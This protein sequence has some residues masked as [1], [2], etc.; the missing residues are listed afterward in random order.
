VGGSLSR[1]GRRGE[2]TQPP[3]LWTPRLRQVCLQ[4]ESAHLLLTGGGRS[5]RGRR[6]GQAVGCEEE[7]ETVRET[8]PPA[9]QLSHCINKPRKE[10]EPGTYKIRK[11][12][13]L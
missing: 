1:V 12:K 6:G 10:A 5:R 8:S 3:G 13:I 9:G 4:T 11:I 2:G 7:E